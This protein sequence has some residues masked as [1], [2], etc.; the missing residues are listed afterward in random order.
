MLYQRSYA[1]VDTECIVPV[2]VLKRT[3]E[4]GLQFELRSE[5]RRAVQWY[6]NRRAMQAGLVQ[7]QP[8]AQMQTVME[9]AEVESEPS[10]GAA[11]WHPSLQ[12]RSPAEL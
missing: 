4:E 12:F 8:S 5:S 7:V 6:L 9:E 11:D 1:R 2:Q 3:P 10:G